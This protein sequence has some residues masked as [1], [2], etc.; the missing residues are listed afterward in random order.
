MHF[1]EFR[2]LVVKAKDI[3]VPSIDTVAVEYTL[4]CHIIL[5]SAFFLV[6]G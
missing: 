1:P 3:R 4:C 6:R 5:I 2:F